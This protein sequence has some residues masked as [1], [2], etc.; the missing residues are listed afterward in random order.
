MSETQPDGQ[1]SLHPLLREG[2]RCLE[3]RLAKMLPAEDLGSTVDSVQALLE[4]GALQASEERGEQIRFLDRLLTRCG[5]LDERLRRMVRAHSDARRERSTLGGQTRTL[6]A[7]M[8]EEL[9]TGSSNSTFDESLQR[10]VVA[11][12]ANLSAHAG[13][14]ELRAGKVEDHLH[15]ASEEIRTLMQDAAKLHRE[16]VRIRDDL[17]TDPVTR[18]PGEPRF[19]EQLA[20][21]CLQALRDGNVMSLLVVD[22]DGLEDVNEAHGRSAGNRTLSAVAE[23]LNEVLRESD[24]AARGTDDEFL[25]LLPFTDLNH[26]QLVAEKVRSAVESLEVEL[27]PATRVAVTASCGVASYWEYDSAVSVLDRARVAARHARNSG[28]NRVHMEIAD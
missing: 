16:L 15:S 23:T 9:L 1:E 19:E 20:R 11:L 7:N 27:K 6:F 28:G 8:R 10:I 24:T 21:E 22:V 12:E 17:E 4:N 3:T 14:E 2:L 5:E 18:L 26:A 25:I 13:R